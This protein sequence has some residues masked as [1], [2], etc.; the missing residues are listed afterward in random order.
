MYFYLRDRYRSVKLE[1]NCLKAR[2]LFSKMLKQKTLE[3]NSGVLTIRSSR[4]LGPGLR[5]SLVPG[6]GFTSQGYGDVNFGRDPH[7]AM[8]VKGCRRAF[9]DIFPLSKKG[10]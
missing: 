6:T 7:V 3:A 9:I 1:L 4:R 2:K 8:R 10:K 5:F